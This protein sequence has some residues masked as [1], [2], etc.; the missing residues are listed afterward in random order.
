LTSTQAHTSTASLVQCTPFPISRACRLPRRRRAKQAKREG[1]LRSASLS[2]GESH[3]HPVP[4]PILTTAEYL[5][6]VRAAA[7]I[8]PGSKHL[9][10]L[11]R[12]SQI[13]LSNAHS[14]DRHAHLH[15]KLTHPRPSHTR[16]VRKQIGCAR[17]FRYRLCH[18]ALV[19]SSACLR[20][21]QHTWGGDW[22]AQTRC[23]PCP[24]SA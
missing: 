9:N 5:K 3:A 6:C 23:H 8:Q 16:G 15:D 11:V 4:R 19:R 2:D 21:G 10:C 18:S 17:A 24:P 20:P 14:Q 22:G 13:T 12:M 1:R 7:R